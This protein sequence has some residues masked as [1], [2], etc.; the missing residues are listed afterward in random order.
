M[1]SC[2]KRKRS[3]GESLV[4]SLLC[5]S[6]SDVE[7]ESSNYGYESSSMEYD[8]SRDVTRTSENDPGDFSA[9][10][11]GRGDAAA[12][13]RE[14]DFGTWKW[15]K[16]HVPLTHDFMESPGLSDNLEAD[17][18]EIMENNYDQVPQAPGQGAALPG[19]VFEALFSSKL[20]DHI[21]V[22]TNK[23]AKQTMGTSGRKQKYQEEKWFDNCRGTEGILWFDLCYA[24]SERIMCSHT[25]QNVR[26]RRLPISLST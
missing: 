2:R 7:Y 1:A 22:E 5:R 24:V 20:L 8:S 9:S 11:D 15:L 25:G 26:P 17:I 12:A 16:K 18:S 13:R 10:D 23:Y 3:V 4:N 6:D 19:A 21:V 14:D